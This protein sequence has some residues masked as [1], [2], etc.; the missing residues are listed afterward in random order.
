MDMSNITKKRKRSAEEAAE[1]ARD[2]AIRNR[3]SAQESRD[4]QKKY[5]KDLEE[6]NELLKEQNET[7]MSRLSAIEEQNRLLMEK[8]NSMAQPSPIL[9]HTPL[10]ME[11][12]STLDPSLLDTLSPTL[13]SEVFVSQTVEEFFAQFQ[14]EAPSC[15]EPPMDPSKA[16]E[17]LFPEQLPTEVSYCTLVEKP[18]ELKSDPAVVQTSPQQMN[19]HSFSTCQASTS[20]AP[21]MLL[22]SCSL[23]DSKPERKIRLNISRWNEF[24][25]K[26]Y[27]LCFAILNRPV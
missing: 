10:S 2:R 15:S 26:Q 23:L 12:V 4:R 20:S 14:S 17:S 6:S 9:P 25:K 1:R 24:L 19:S 21:S 11:S 5:I 16:F 18:F 13:P 7:L 8:L 27:P 22:A 3:I